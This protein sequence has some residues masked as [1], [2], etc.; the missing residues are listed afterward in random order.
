MLTDFFIFPNKRLI[1]RETDILLYEKDKICNDV[2]YCEDRLA[3]CLRLCL[4]SECLYTG[5]TSKLG[6]F[7]HGYRPTTLLYIKYDPSSLDLST[8]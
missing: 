4:Y 2:N 8:H 7:S 3:M 1:P 5:I 6:Q